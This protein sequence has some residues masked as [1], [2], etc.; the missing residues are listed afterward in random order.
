MT[1]RPLSFRVDDRVIIRRIGG[2]IGAKVIKINKVSAWVQVDGEP[3]KRTE[4]LSNMQPETA[5]HVAVREHQAALAEWRSQRPQISRCHTRT[6]WDG[7]ELDVNVFG[8]L[9]T[10]AEMRA[11]A[12]ELQALAAW[13][14]VRP[15]L[16][17]E[18]VES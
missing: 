9:R 5:R 6:G 12:T 15:V 14:V 11:A 13:F 1:T 7:V 10:P 17:A 18:D 3:E 4:V 2:S 8:A 16:H